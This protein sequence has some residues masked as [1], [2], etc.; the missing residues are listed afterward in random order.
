MKALGVEEIDKAM[1]LAMVH[2]LQS[3]KNRRWRKRW[4]CPWHPHSL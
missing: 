4:Q 3:R 1:A 2:N